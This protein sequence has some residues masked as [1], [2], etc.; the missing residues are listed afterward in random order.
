MINSVVWISGVQQNDSIIHIH[1]CCC[2]VTGSCLT[3]LWPHG[4][5]PAIL[6]CPWDFPGENPG[7]GC[8]FLLHG[9]F[10]PSDQTCVSCTGWQ[11]VYC[12][13]TR[14]TLVLD[15]YMYIV[16]WKA[17]TLLCWQRSY[18]QSYGLP[19]G[20]VQLWELDC[21]EG[22]VP[23]N[24]CLWTVVLEKTLESPLNCKEIQP[25]NLKGN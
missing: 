10:W 3:L 4:L 1:V 25:L 23:K 11:I 2:L 5:W 24:W 17:K 7:M 6:L 9:I 8:H 15:V 13:V 22:W 16:Y 21:R 14:E 18:G 19:S 20:H 12:W